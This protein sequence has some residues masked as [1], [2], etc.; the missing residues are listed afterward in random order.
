MVVKTKHS[1][2]GVWTFTA[3]ELNGGETLVIDTGIR[4]VAIGGVY[5]RALNNCRAIYQETARV[6]APNV[7][8]PQLTESSGQLRC[9]FINTAAP[10]NQSGG[11][12]A[13]EFLHSATR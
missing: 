12:V 3:P 11:E 10:G 1:H 8:P 13:I 4:L 9:T 5:T 6:G 2:S 7:P